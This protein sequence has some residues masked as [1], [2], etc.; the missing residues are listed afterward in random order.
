[1]MR[2]YQEVPAE[3]WLLRL[4]D[5]CLTANQKKPAGYIAKQSCLF[6]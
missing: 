1:M 2:P 3:A 5:R 6:E 4:V